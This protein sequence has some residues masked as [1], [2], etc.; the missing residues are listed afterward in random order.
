MFRFV[1]PVFGLMACNGAGPKALNTAPEA[2]I[3]SHEDGSEVALVSFRGQVS[4]ADD[5]AS[6][7]E[8]TWSL[9][10]TVLCPAAVPEEDGSTACEAVIPPDASDLH[11]EVVD[12]S[13]ALGSD[14]VILVVVAANTAPTLA[15]VSLGPTTA[16]ESTILTCSAGATGDEDG[17]TVTLAYA[18]T[19]DGNNPGPTTS[20]LTGTSFDRDQAVA[21]H[22]TPSDGSTDGSTVSSSSVTIANTAP[23]IATVAIRPDPA[24]TI[25]T[26]SCTYTG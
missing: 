2:T 24:R 18:W 1:V 14:G 12:K 4:D 23:S 3:S 15:S 6:M 13:G 21:C 16:Y 17:D 26:L 8:A 9:G 25:D 22:V 11:L 7:L 5:A 10:S 20:T 19:V